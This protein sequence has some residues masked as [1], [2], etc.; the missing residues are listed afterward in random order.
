MERL[1][2]G[3]SALT[4]ARDEVQPARSKE[5]IEQEI[6]ALDRKISDAAIELKDLA[7][8]EAQQK[9]RLAVADMERDYCAAKGDAETF[10]ARVSVLGTDLKSGSSRNPI[11]QCRAFRLTMVNFCLWVRASITSQARWH[12]ASHWL[13]SNGWQIKQS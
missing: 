11:C 9:Q 10:E 2:N 13:W 12:C 7:V 3:Q 4:A 5:P 1:Q 6:A 8:Y